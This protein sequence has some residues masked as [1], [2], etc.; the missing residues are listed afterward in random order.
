MSQVL[1]KRMREPFENYTIYS[2]GKIYSS[3]SN[4]FLSVQL[5][6]SGYL[7]AKLYEHNVEHKCLVHRLVA[8]YFCDK[9]DG[10]DVVNH[11]DGNRL[12]NFY[13]NLEWTTQRKNLREAHKLGFIKDRQPFPYEA[14]NS[15]T[16]EVYLFPSY[17]EAL[18]Y[19]GVNPGRYCYN[20]ALRKLLIDDT[21]LNEWFQVTHT[22][23][24]IRVCSQFLITEFEWD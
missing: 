9:P 13:R 19:L 14:A 18:R 22:D 17:K 12:N 1:C 20:E 5:I 3:K 24:F 10:C 8:E 16:G 4:R 11:I 15:V 2:D 23:W 6:N 21:N 7:L